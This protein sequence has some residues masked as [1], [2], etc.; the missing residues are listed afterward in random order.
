[1]SVDHGRLNSRQ[2]PTRAT[3]GIST[4]RSAR[5]QRHLTDTQAVSRVVLARVVVW[6]ALTEN[7]ARARQ[8]TLMSWQ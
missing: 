7:R 5:N 3:D 8:P 4:Q 6:Q 1:M 2:R